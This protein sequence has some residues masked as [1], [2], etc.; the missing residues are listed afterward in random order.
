MCLYVIA[1]Y[2]VL[3]Q[4]HRLFGILLSLEIVRLVICFN[5]VY[6]FENIQRVACFVL[7]FLCFEVCVISTCLSLIVRFFK[8]IGSDYVR[9]LAL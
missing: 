3:L 5:F 4:R 7:V 9:V 6:V 2:C 1:V 8:G